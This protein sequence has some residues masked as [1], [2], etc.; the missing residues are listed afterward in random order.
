MHDPKHSRRPRGAVSI[1]A[2][3]IATVVTALTVV[4][5]TQNR[6]DAERH[7]APGRLIEVEGTRDHLLCL[8]EGG[9]TTVLVGGLGGV[10]Q[11]WAWVQ[12]PLA[13][14]GRV[15]AHDRPGY[16]FSAF[17]PA[18]DDPLDEAARL[19]DVLTAAG[20]RG[21]F[22]L[23]GHSLGGHYA[24]AFAST[25]PDEV[26][27]LVLVDARPPD[28]A[29]HVP[30]HDDDVRRTAS[31]LRW[32]L[33]LAPLG[34]LRAFG[35]GAKVAATLPA[36]VRE[37]VVAR[38]AN[39]DH[40]RRLV[41]ELEALP[42]L[43]AAAGRLELPD[44]VPALAVTA[45]DAPDGMSEDTWRTLRTIVGDA[46]VALPVTEVRAVEGA[47]HLSL[48]T[49]EAHAGAVAEAIASWRTAQRGGP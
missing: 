32:G 3:A 18:E 28:V 25:Y 16:G 12:R 39:A 40:A 35:G 34:A 14:D 22:V 30:G 49:D 1:A 27:G 7:A 26:A 19:A 46:A 37:A 48:L 43:D 21:P 11:G 4:E 23:V 17:R 36:D 31:M 13:E 5:A 2:L 33:R 44:G 41:S 24:R 9:P 8:G 20:E 45:T 10:A 6:R 15:C 47:D 42:A 29:D 38:M